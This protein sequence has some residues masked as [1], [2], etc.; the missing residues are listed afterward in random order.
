LWTFMG[1]SIPA[2]TLLAFLS[3]ATLSLAQLF[4]TSSKDVL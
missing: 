4:R 1:L 2:W 3:L